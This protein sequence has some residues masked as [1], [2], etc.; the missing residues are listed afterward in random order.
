MSPHTLPFEEVARRLQTDIRQG[1]TDAD[2][3]KA[4]ERCGFNELPP[5][6]ETPVWL[7]FLQEFHDPIMYILIVA[8]IVNALVAEPKDA[9]VIAFVVVLNTVVGFIQERR[10]EQA[11][12]SLKKIS[13]P[14]ARVLRN[15]SMI[16]IPAREIVCGDI[17]LVESGT[18]VA[19][20]ARIVEAS[21]LQVDESML[22]GESLPVT[23]N[24]HTVLEEHMPLGDRINMLFAGTIVQRGRGKAI[25][26]GTGEHTEFSRISIEI[27]NVD[28]S[29]SPLQERLEEFGRYLSIA[30]IATV[31]I[32]FTIGLLQGNSPLTMALTAIGLAVSAIP[33]GL[34]MSVT[35]TLSI[36]MRIMAKRHAVIRKLVAVETLGSTNVICSDKTGTL[37]RNQMTAVKALTLA[38]STNAIEWNISGTGYDKHGAI[39]DAVGNAIDITQNH[40]LLWLVRTGLLCTE[41]RLKDLGADVPTFEIVGDPTEAALLVLAHKA[42]ISDER[43]VWKVTVDLP[44]ESERQF[45]GVTVY[46]DGRTYILVKGS[47]ERL[48]ARSSSIMLSDGTYAPINET[49]LHDYNERFA[50]LGLRVLLLAMKEVP[51]ALP[52]EELEN[53]QNLVCLGLVGIVDPAREEAREAIA[54]CRMAGIQ[55]KMI[56]G[57]HAK[58]AQAIASEL[59]LAGERTPQVVTGRELECMSDE[60]LH[61]RVQAI[62]VYARVSPTDKLRIVKQLQRYDLVVAMTGDGVNDAPALKQA[63]IGIAMGSG[64]DVAKDVSGMVITDDNFVSI[65]AAVRRGRVIFSN[66]RHILIYILT[67]SLGGV[68]TVASSVFIGIPLPILPAQLLWINLVTDGTSTFPLAFEKEHGNVMRYKPR[69]RGE[70]LLSGRMIGHIVFCGIWMMVGTLALFVYNLYVLQYPL[71]KAQTAAFC[72]LALFQIWN[73]QNSRSLER[74]LFWHLP[75]RATGEWIERISFRDNIPLLG[76]ML[77]AIIMQIGAVELPLLDGL[78]NTPFSLSVEDWT[79]II[80][81]SLSII[82]VVEIEKLVLALKQRLWDKK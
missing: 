36:G 46:R 22:T 18:R 77:F 56:T 32:I 47:L 73:V 66:L 64:T 24:P 68:L 76:V 17:L 79:R 53:I 67:T 58:T 1:L 21:M 38:T 61:Q 42:G 20:D 65:A 63:D 5:Q 31:I 26:T 62:D 15:G 69:K 40:A 8:A 30:I 13:A 55:V 80:G 29:K 82:A 11:L 81:V 54:E 74:S 45:M 14:T 2:V 72:T 41:S 49:L 43:A 57:D 60:E 78:L 71:L 12:Q 59:R 48:L 9:L 7:Q 3:Q 39:T 50:G 28:D 35:I 16:E 6:K 34:P 19:A 51:E 23:K 44:F 27:Q 75:G 52:P 4:R 70:G 33:E 37:T 25:V 10:A